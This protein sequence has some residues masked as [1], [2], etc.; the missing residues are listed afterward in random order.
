LPNV[1]L[2]LHWVIL[3]FV[4][5]ALAKFILPGRDPAGCLVTTGLGIIGAFIGGWIGTRLGWGTVTAAHFNP[6]SLALA[7]L[8]AI[9][10]LILGRFLRGSPPS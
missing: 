5:G 1:P 9:L 6:R 7:T 4:A 2:W 10:V 3:G 8:G